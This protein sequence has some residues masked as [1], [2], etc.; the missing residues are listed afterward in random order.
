MRYSGTSAGILAAFAIA[1][2][3][4][5]GVPQPVQAAGTERV[6][7]ASYPRLYQGWRA[8]VIVGT[9]VEGLLGE[10]LG[11]VVDLV[12]DAATPASTDVTVNSN[13]PSTAVG[14]AAA[15]ATGA[16]LRWT[17]GRGPEPSLQSAP[18]PPSS[19]RE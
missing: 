2:S 4:T 18:R 1:T 13:L 8:G 11:Q 16:A 12:V 10:E 3:L 9:E 17:R 7:E 14:S 15:S 6:A 19:T 5:L